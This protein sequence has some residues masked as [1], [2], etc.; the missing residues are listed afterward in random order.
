MAVGKLA[1]KCRNYGGPIQQ[2]LR[3]KMGACVSVGVIPDHL[4]R[5]ARRD[6]S[7]DNI[8]LCQTCFVASPEEKVR[9]KKLAEEGK[10]EIFDAPLEGDHYWEDDCE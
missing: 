8:G 9:R 7:T 1:G 2:S 4:V 5:V 6:S 10:L 3:L